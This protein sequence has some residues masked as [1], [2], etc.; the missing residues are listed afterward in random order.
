MISFWALWRS[1]NPSYLLLVVGQYMMLGRI[2]AA[3]QIDLDAV[4]AG[5]GLGSA[6]V[7]APGSDT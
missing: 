7:A 1:L 3:T 5:G 4:N 2:M 6:D